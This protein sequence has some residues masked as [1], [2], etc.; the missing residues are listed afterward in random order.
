MFEQNQTMDTPDFADFATATDGCSLFSKGN[1]NRLAEKER[2]KTKCA[3][4]RAEQKKTQRLVNQRDTMY[5]A[6]L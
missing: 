5:P 2:E 6:I 1:E 3:F 4:D